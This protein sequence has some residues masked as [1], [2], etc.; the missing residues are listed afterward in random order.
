VWAAALLGEHIGAATV[1]AALAVLACVVA[2]QR[3]RVG[4]R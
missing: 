1:A 3:A 4:S 2:T